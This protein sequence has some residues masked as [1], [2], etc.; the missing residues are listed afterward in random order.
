MLFKASAPSS[1]MLLG[2]YAVLHGKQALVCAVNKR[3]TVTLTPRAD[4]K[5]HIQSALGVLETDLKQLKIAPP[6]QFVLA[7]FQKYRRHLPSGCDLKIEAEFSDKIGFGSSAAVTVATLSALAAWLNITFSAA[8][9]IRAARALVQKVQGLGSG[10]DV[11]AC[12]LGGIVAYKMQPLLAEKFTHLHPLTVVYS[13][14][15]TPTV[16]AVQQVKQRYLTQPK[17]FKSLFQTME[18]CTAEGI[19]AV[20]Q[21]QWKKLGDSMNIQQGLLEALG[22]STPL[23]RTIVDSLREQNTILGAK[24][25]GSGLGD[26]LVGLGAAS[27]PAWADDKAQT[28]SVAM[29]TQGVVC[30]KIG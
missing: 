30:E 10:A 15:K 14:Y 9:F 11:A 2:E 25:S 19:Q 18:L 24:I 6:F 29:T 16:E 20:R 7:V 17:I 1:L 28:I 5:I 8:D 12:V 13:G 3:M 27:L 4:N 23:L 21:Q 26:C 22:V